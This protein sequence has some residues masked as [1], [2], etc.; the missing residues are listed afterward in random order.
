MWSRVT[1]NRLTSNRSRRIVA[2]CLS[3][4]GMPFVKKEQFCEVTKIR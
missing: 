3:A 4:T 2:Y 1:S